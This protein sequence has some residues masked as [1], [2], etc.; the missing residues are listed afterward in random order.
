MNLPTF[1]NEGDDWIEIG[2]SDG[3]GGDNFDP[4]EDS[5]VIGHDVFITGGGFD[6]ADGEGGDDIMVFSDGE[7][8]F[9]GGGGFDWASYKFDRLGVSADLNVN[10][11][12][13]PPV[14]PSNQGILDRFAD[15]E[16]LSGS[17]FS[18]MLRGDDATA[19]DIDIAGPLNGVL[20]R[21]GLIDGLQDLLGAGVTS[22][23]SGNIILGGDGS[24]ILEGR[25]GDD[26]ID[27]DRMLNVRVSVRDPNDP[28]VEIRSVDSLAELIPDM[29]AG[30]INP[31]QLQIVREI[32]P[33]SGGFNFDTAV[34]T[35]N[36]ADYTV[37]IND[38]GT[39]LVFSDDIVT[40]TDNV[41]DRDG[42]D[43]L[44][45]IERLQFND[46]TRVLVEGL[47]IRAGGRTDHQRRHA[48]R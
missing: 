40:V 18:D 3:A 8:H 13:E 25:G 44:T 16:G 9:G 30:T 24:D 36:Q 28:N 35:G 11:L 39:P 43:R 20:T 4:Q 47:N 21:I 42:I 32:L 1:G 14:A 17:A 2:T 10:D 19:E 5:T 31:G 37:V 34:F 41:A 12:I 38:N 27:G 22:F 6:E 33:G 26:L 45:H 23:G 48:G 15:V 29:L 46:S 7:D